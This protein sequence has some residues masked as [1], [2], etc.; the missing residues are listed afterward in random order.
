LQTIRTG[1]RTVHLEVPAIPHIFFGIAGEWN[2][3]L[4]GLPD[5]PR[6]RAEETRSRYF[7]DLGRNAAK[8]AGQMD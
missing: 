6:Y 4:H 7:W 5:L 8:T 3:S 1:F 2:D